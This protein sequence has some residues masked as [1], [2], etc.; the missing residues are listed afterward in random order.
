M[1]QSLRR[2]DKSAGV[3]E[4]QRHLATLGF[5]VEGDDPGLFG[6]ATEAAV[7]AFQQNRGLDVDGVV[8]E[9][10]SRELAESSWS[11]GDR[12]L[13]T[14]DPPMTGD[15]VRG[16]QE[17]L[18]A[19][20]FSAG[21]HDGIFGAQTAEAVREFQQNL[22]IEEDGIVGPETVRALERL[23]L[24][25]R[26]GLGPRVRER[27]TRRA[28][29]PGLAGK[30]IAIDPGHGGEDPGHTS[31]SGENEADL[32]FRLAASVTRQLDR[33]GAISM[34]TRG[35]HDGPTDSE[36]ADLANRF[37]AGLLVSIHLNSTSSPTAEGAATYFFEHGGVAS[38]PGEHLADVM[39]QAL[40][41]AGR[42][43]CRSHGRNYAL[44]RET[45][46]P[47]LVVEPGFI[48]NP[49]EAKLL[50]D[51]E[52]IERVAQAIVDGVGRYFTDA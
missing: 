36:R 11:V 20:G 18:N 13:F 22:A 21:K 6:A 28:V 8:G 52:G 39:G 44:L 7:R 42:N 41:A 43:D 37:G 35:P 50:A 29:P 38:E 26:P 48:S 4:V 15:D 31:S 46:M 27:E 25:L 40:V 51:P 30:R 14:T 34:L 3:E 33:A 5:P 2:G 47:A 16:L 19:L 45:R 24:V 12:L 9:Y 1:K 17:K 49:E 23:R 32:V 10:T